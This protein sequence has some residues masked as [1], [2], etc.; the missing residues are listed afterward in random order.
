MGLQKPRENIPFDSQMESKYS[1]AT[2]CLPGLSVETQGFQGLE[3]LRWIHRLLQ[4]C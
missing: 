4:D 1:V 3:T 2:I